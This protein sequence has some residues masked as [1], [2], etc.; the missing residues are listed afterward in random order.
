MI[1][2]QFYMH[3]QRSFFIFVERKSLDKFSKFNIIKYLTMVGNSLMAQQKFMGEKENHSST[4][5]HV[6]NTYILD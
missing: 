5:I 2:A 4:H 3:Y 6:S 1:I